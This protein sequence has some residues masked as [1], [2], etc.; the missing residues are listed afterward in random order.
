MSHPNPSHYPNKKAYEK[1]LKEYKNILQLQIKLNKQQEVNMR[2]AYKTGAY[3]AG[4]QLPHQRS[5]FY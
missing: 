3:D 1:A 2:Q 4:L 5:S